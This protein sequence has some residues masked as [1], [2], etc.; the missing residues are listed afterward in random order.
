MS[1][2]AWGQL[3]RLRPAAIDAIKAATPI[4]YIPWGAIE[5]HSYHAPVG[6]DGHQAL[7]QCTALATATGGVVL[8]PIYVGTDTIKPFKGFPHTLEYDGTVVRA[9]AR[10]TLEQLAAEDF[11]VLVIVTGHCGGAHVDA[12]RE[13]VEAFAESGSDAEVLLIPSFEPIQAEHPSNHAARGETSFQM[14][15]EP[16]TVDLSAQPPGPPPTLDDDGVWGED[17][18]D[19]TADEGRAMLSLFVSRTVPAILSLLNATES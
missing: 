7:G 6:L 4:A 3:D 16:E 13:T 5:W 2:P 19:A 17:P 10:Q 18:R 8:P 14:L 11:R 15:F 1:Q 12:L 9:L